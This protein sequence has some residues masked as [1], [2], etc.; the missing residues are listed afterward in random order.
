MNSL[1]ISAK[2]LP[3]ISRGEDISELGFSSDPT[4][5]ATIEL[6]AVA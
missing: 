4:I 5:L 6:D 1:S 3:F 2:P